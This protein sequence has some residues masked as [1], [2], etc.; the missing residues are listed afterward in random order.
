MTQLPLR[1]TAINF[2]I[3]DSLR[4][5]ASLYVC[6]AHCRGNLWIGGEKYLQQ[7]PFNTW[8][9][10]DWI[11]MLSMSLTK[12]SG[13]AVIFFFVLSGFSI[14]HSLQ[15]QPSVKLFLLKRFIRL[16]PPYLLGFLLAL[17]SVVLLKTNYDLYLSGRYETHTFDLFKN[18]VVLFEPQ[19]IINTLLYQPL[20]GTV[21]TPYWSL[22]YEVIFYVAAIFFVRNLKW[23]YWASVIFFI[24]GIVIE[25]TMP[26]LQLNSIFLKFILRYNFYF[27][28]GIYT[29]HNLERLKEM[30]IMN[31]SYWIPALLIMYAAMIGVESL[32]KERFNLSFI[33]AAVCCVTMMVV[34]LKKNIQIKFLQKIGQY[35]YTLY[36]VHF[37]VIT[38]IVWFLFSVV[39]LTPPDLNNFFLW[40]PAVFICLGVS[41][42]M[43]LLVE[44]PSKK[45]LNKL[46]R[47]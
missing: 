44:N 20:L 3:L 38:A 33:I 28:I 31:S 27:M 29:Y 6:I 12:L 32:I 22:V 10:Q 13:E 1:K 21:I 25:I 34:F 5:L 17:L 11:V 45:L 16:Y 9:I 39:K 43:Y 37:S 40:M 41:Y 36:V 30:K 42:L 46:R 26:Q 35:S 24:A 14:A 4:G 2:A 19:T 7:H 23:Y 18:S 15:S 8:N 47:R